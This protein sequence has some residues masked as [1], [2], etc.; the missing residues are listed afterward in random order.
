[1]LAIEETGVYYKDKQ[2]GGLQMTSFYS[3]KTSY[4]GLDIIILG[5]EGGAEFSSMEAWLVP[6]YGMNLCRFLVEGRSVIDFDTLLLKAHDYTGTPVLYPTPNRVRNGRFHYNGRIY[7]Q[8]KRDRLILEHGLVHDEMFIVSKPLVSSNSVSISASIEFTKGS[9]LYTAFPFEHNLNLAFT[10]DETGIT[11]AY[12]I[13]NNDSTVLP[14]GFGLHPYFNKLDGEIQTQVML[15]AQYVMDYTSDLLPTGRLVGV[16]GTLFDLTEPR[17]IGS[18]D[19]DHVYTCIPPDTHACIF[20]AASG[21]RI[22][23]V[24]TGDFSHLVIYSPSGESYFCIENQ[25]CSTDAHN[26]YDAG[27]VKESGLKMVNPGETAGGSVSYR[28]SHINLL[29]TI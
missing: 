10:L 18:L 22:D 17:S 24:P 3:R 7:V 28:I 25:T 9:T 29:K 5:Y 14:F 4:D 20:Y 16:E 2:K 26:L 15:P 6:H 12:R 13:K 11:A 23:L 21:L 8:K 19:L 1:M 27:F